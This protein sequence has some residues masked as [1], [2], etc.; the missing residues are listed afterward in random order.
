MIKFAGWQRTS[1]IDFP[2]K[3]SSVLFTQGCSMR[4]RFCHNP[5]LVQSKKSSDFLFQEEEILGYL[6]QRRNMIEGVVLTGGEPTLQ[7]DLIP[8]IQK[9]H[10]MGYS[11]KLDTNGYQPTKLQEI[12]QTGCVEYVAM[13]VKAPLAL[14]NNV[15]GVAIQTNLIQ[16]SLQILLQSNL[17]YELRTTAVKPLLSLED[18]KTI[19]QEI[20]GAPLWILQQFR[21]G[22]TLDLA[23]QDT[24]PYKEEE[25][26]QIAKE[27]SPL[28]VKEC[29][30]R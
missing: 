8:F 27:V 2:G 28:Y 1:L 21:S 20:A 11:I 13:D 22:C 19:A 10:S 25:L 29:K 26:L 6:A 14:Y 23:L 12:L 17:P 4:C 7:P 16:K 3:I 5:E 9:V 18:L 30:V 15:A 24:E